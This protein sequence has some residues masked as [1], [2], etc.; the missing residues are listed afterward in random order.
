MKK[1][2]DNLFKYLYVCL[3]IVNDITFTLQTGSIVKSR[4]N[5]INDN[6]YG[7]KYSILS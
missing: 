4:K 1:V 6:E 3:M 5:K 2:I 7:K